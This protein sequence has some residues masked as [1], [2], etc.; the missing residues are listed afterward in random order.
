VLSF[1]HWDSKVSVEM[2]GARS[3]S[4]MAVAAVLDIARPSARAG[5]LSGESFVCY[6][7]GVTCGYHLK[8]SEVFLI[9]SEILHEK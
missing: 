7:Y 9:N 8:T 6:E 2:G 5:E 3:H 1:T 4:L